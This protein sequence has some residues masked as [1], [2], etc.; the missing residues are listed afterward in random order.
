MYELKYFDEAIDDLREVDNS[1]RVVLQK[2]IMKRLRSPRVPKDALSGNL[3]GAYKLKDSKTG[4]RL[5][6]IVLD[7]QNTVLVFAVDRRDK[8]RAYKV[9]AQRID[10][11]FSALNRD[12]KEEDRG[13]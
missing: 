13:D 8:F 10:E 2:K 4:Y 1:V 7:E 9:G 11:L 5:L 3:S 6:Y 12:V